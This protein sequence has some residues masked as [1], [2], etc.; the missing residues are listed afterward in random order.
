MTHDLTR[1]DIIDGELLD[2][3]DCELGY[4]R[5]CTNTDVALVDNPYEADVNNTPG[6]LIWACPTCL[7]ELAD[8]I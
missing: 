3:Q 8:D 6:Q 2:E 7:Q 5:Y 1:T 4:D